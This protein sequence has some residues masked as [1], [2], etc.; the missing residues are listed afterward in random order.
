VKIC[1]IHQPRTFPRAFCCRTLR[2]GSRHG[3]NRPPWAFEISTMIAGKQISRGSMKTKG[4]CTMQLNTKLL[5]GCALSVMLAFAPTALMAQDGDAGTT[6]QMPTQQDQQMQSGDG[7]TS[8]AA[9]QPQVT[10]D[11]PS[12][13]SAAETV[14][15]T[16]SDSASSADTGTTE[17]SQSGSSDTGAADTARDQTTGAPTPD[18]GSADEDTASAPVESDQAGDQTA[19]SP[20]DSATSSVATESKETFISEQEQEQILARGSLIGKSVM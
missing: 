7:A 19:A 3:T 9:D 11:Q 5:A 18:A 4:D 14:A 6:A 12:E 2:I 8:G 13:D 15:R 10:T 20:S 1:K 16:D 17:T